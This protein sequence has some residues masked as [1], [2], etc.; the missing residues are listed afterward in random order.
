MTDQEHRDSA[1]H[2]AEV[3]LAYADG[4]EIECLSGNEWV[5]LPELSWGWNS[6]CYRVAP[7]PP[8]PRYR[9]FATV[10]EAMPHVGRLVRHDH[11]GAVAVG[12][13]EIDVAY[14]GDDEWLGLCGCPRFPAE[15]LDHAVFLDTGEPVGVREDAQ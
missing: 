1:R 3:M 8:K 13:L 4:R 11:E 7:T 5:P 10:E 14:V 9:P 2:M 12:M 6:A 15:M